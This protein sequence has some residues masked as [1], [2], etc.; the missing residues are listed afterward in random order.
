[1]S[2]RLGPI[3]EGKKILN[4]TLD[5]KR[6]AFEDQVSGDS[7]WVWIKNLSGKAGKVEIHFQ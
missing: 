7:K 1:M 5:G 2:L 3:P 4:A 6:L